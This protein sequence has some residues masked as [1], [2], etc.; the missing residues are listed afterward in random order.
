M[1]LKKAKL[2]LISLLSAAGALCTLGVA[3]TASA[4][5]TVCNDSATD[6]FF[7]TTWN[8]ATQCGSEPFHSDGWY[9]IPKCSCRD[10]VTGNVK[11]LSFWWSAI[12][13]T[14]SL[15]FWKGDGSNVWPVEWAPPMFAFA[16]WMTFVTPTR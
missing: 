15:V 6:V 14:D 5:L 11:N 16:P 3:S 1:G 10:V 4:T 2:G 7:E 8:G 9:F 13:S 12:S